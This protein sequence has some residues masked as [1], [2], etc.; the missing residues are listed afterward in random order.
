MTDQ[1]SPGKSRRRKV[2]IAAAVAIV[3][4]VA[5]MVAIPRDRGG[6]PGQTERSP[7][8][9]YVEQYGGSQ[10]VYDRIAATSDC[11]ELQAS[12][13]RAAADNDRAD[14]GTPEHR[15]TLGY[16]TAADERMKAVGCY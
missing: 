1:A 11:G 4:L 10:A 15:W 5:L 16:M 8:A 14:A 6:A 2:M 13:D 9:N 7:A 3:V 12:F